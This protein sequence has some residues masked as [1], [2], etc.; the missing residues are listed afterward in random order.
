MDCPSRSA[1]A[2]V[3]EQHPQL[4]LID[5]VSIGDSNARLF[6]PSAGVPIRQDRQ[7]L[8]QRLELV[9]IDQDRRGAAIAGDDDAI[10][11]GRHPVDDF[12][13]SSFGFRSGAF[14]WSVTRCAY[15]P[16]R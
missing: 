15:S 12:R 14:A 1:A 13:E 8:L 9:G 10:V 16:P 6:K 11:R 2:K 4:S 3:V 7:G 5:G